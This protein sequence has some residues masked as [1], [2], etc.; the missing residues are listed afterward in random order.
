MKGSRGASAVEFAIV[1]PV[2]L[3][4]LFGTIEFGILL[5]NK[6]VI[7][8]A[9][10]EGARF[11]IVS[12]PTRKTDA[13]ISAVV[14]SYK[15]THLITFGTPN[16]ADTTCTRTGTAFGD[17]LSVRVQYHYDFL[18][19]P[20]FVGSLIGGTDIVTTTVMKYE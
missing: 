13:E 18:V 5:F 20:N 10:R 7:T 16:S 2:L 6:Q 3:L 15:S 12:G 8:N 17:D 19:L 11:G 1:L 9:S 4:I 14:D